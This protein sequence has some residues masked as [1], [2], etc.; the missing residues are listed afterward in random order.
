MKILAISDIHGEPRFIDE[1]SGLIND[2]DLIAI[3]GDISHTGKVDSVELILGEIEKI[4]RSI[5]AVHGNWDRPEIHDL[6]RE[7]GYSL[8]GSGK[9]IKGLGFF[10]VGGSTPTP[11][12]TPSEFS[13]EEILDFL[14]SGYQAIK[15]IE[16]RIL[17]SHTPPHHTRD[18]TFLGLRG[19]SHSVKDFIKEHEIDLCLCGHIH[20]AS[21]TEQINN[22][23]VV[24]P[25]SF[26]KG[27]YCTVD[28][29]DN[30]PIFVEH[31]RLKKSLLS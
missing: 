28:I 2:A 13:E 9:V 29:S 26:K 31:G 12:K 11:M 18:K 4:N 23:I 27:K 20:E 24:N 14:K 1:A 16:T 25:G 30:G 22:C 10:G 5:I 8:H 7:R 21:G 3:C 19:G 6:L 17:L 15:D